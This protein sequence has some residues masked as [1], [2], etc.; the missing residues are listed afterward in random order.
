[1]V[2]FPPATQ[3]M[4]WIIETDMGVDDQISIV[5]MA[6]KSLT[7]DAINIKAVLTQGNGLA[8]VGPAKN[9]AVRLLRLAGLKPT[10]LPDVGT[11]SQYGLDGFHQY[12][13]DWRYNNDKLS[14]VSIPDYQET[15]QEHNQ[16]SESLLRQ[17]LIRSKE[18]NQP[19]SILSLG[20]F[21]NIAKVL[22]ESPELGRQITQIVCMTGA[23]DVPGNL[24]VHGFSDDAKNRFAEFNAWIDPIATKMV[25]ESGIPI[26]LI[27]LDITNNAPLTEDFL[28]RFKAKTSGEAAITIAQWWQKNLK[29]ET[30]EYYNWD[31]LATAIALNPD[32]ITKQKTIKIT[33]QANRTFSQ[34]GG[35]VIFGEKS[36]FDILNWQGHSR[37]SFNPYNAGRTQRS[38][39]GQAVDVIFDADIERYQND[40][41]ATFSSQT[42]NQ[43]S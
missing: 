23:V 16:S 30:G 4:D 10:E 40:L 3:A 17:H 31:P 21:T 11:G 36:D 39:S 29:P 24:R 33:V 1:M 9:N 42:S 14:N 32:I 20:T 38:R 12:P 25:I 28:D 27:P 6:A 15:W 34:Q 43:R 2:G 5:Y 37:R 13:A 26:K 19:I 7:S 41:I 35:D 8:H 22:H 18:T